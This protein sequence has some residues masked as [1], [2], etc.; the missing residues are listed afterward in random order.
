M[1][2]FARERHIMRR[3]LRMWRDHIR[4]LREWSPN[5]RPYRPNDLLSLGRF[6]KTRPLG[7][8]CSR[9]RCAICSGHKYP[10]EP[11]YQERKHGRG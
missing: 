1:K 10:R 7:G 9:P 4:E 6:R 5:V 3:R 8:M 2:R 11:S